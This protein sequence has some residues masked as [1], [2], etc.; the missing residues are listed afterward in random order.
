MSKTITVRNLSFKTDGEG[1]RRSFQ[2]DPI[3][4]AFYAALSSAFP[5][6]ENFFVRSVAQFAKQVPPELKVEVDAFIRQ[7]ALHS[8]EHVKFNNGIGDAGMPIEALIKRSSKQLDDADARG[9]INRLCTTVALEHF[10]SVFAEKILSDPRHLAHYDGED[11]ALW[12]WHAIEEI[13]HKAVAF[14]VF[15]HITADWSPLRRYLCRTGAMLDAMTRLAVLM[16]RGS[17]EV[18]A[19]QGVK[20][21]GWQWAFLAFLFYKPGLLSAMTPQLIAFFKPGFHPNHIDEGD[22]LARA[23]TALAPVAA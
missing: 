19:S 18:L 10:T 20:T 23:K 21:P 15:N 2:V 14:D 17:G 22:L 6:G 4:V 7:E 5:H 13:E 11:L 8:R 3:G 1:T 16:W 12:Q 9:P